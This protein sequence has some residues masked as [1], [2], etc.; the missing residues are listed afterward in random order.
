MTLIFK[1]F[2]E[3]KRNWSCRFKYVPLC[4]FPTIFNILLNTCDIKN[5][6]HS[7]RRTARYEARRNDTNDRKLCEF[8][9]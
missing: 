1:E 3:M 9:K 4:I 7:K 6:I 2:K 5:A 8:H